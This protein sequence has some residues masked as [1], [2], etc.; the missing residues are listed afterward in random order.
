MPQA[1]VNIGMVGHI[2]HG[3]TTL[4]EA[5]T[6]VWTDTHSEEMK[7]GITIKLGYADATFY[8][9]PSCNRYSTGKRCPYCG[10]ETVERRR[11]SFVDAPGHEMLMATM[12]AGAAIMDGAV[13]VIAANEKCPQPQTK[14]HL[15]ALK[16]IG[17]K[18]I[19]VAQ[20]KIELVPKEKVIE[21]YQQI[22]GFLEEMGY[23]DAPVIPVSAIH[24]ANI[25][26]LIEA[27][28]KHIPTPKRDLDKPPLMFVARSFDVNRP[29]T[30]PE[31][32]VGG[33]VGGSLSRG[34]LR[35]GDEIAI[36][37]GIEIAKGGRK[38][39]QALETKIVGLQAMKESL[40]EA[41]PGG[42]IG[43]GTE[44]DPSLTKADALVGSVLGLRGHL[45]ELV[46]K[47]EVE[48]KLLRRVVGLPEELE[49]R[50]LSV[51]EPV[52]VNVGTATRSGVVTHI[53][54]ERAEI[55]L[56][57]PVCAE[58]GWR[59]AIS[60]RVANKWRLIGYGIIT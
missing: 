23:P 54:G 52:V 22:K 39:W 4:T 41:R 35:V 28:E 40:E 15:M 3:K 33:V 46:E 27:I 18:N 47:V 55:N 48:V 29:G 43:V 2:D 50:P 32:L 13:L 37:P 42:L 44:L 26:K 9:C 25:D 7:R 45:P 51:G 21:N 38:S 56:K 6:G 58:K 10:G 49:V 53:K 57:Y 31:K 24:R 1:E 11:V 59:I 19:V 16:I 20:N 5:L 30:P 8:L 12:L 17:V 14:E 36:E 34:K 60:R